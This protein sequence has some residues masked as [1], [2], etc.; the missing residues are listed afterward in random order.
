M[1]PLRR[2]SRL[3]Y[4]QFFDSGEVTRMILTHREKLMW[5]ATPFLRLLWM[6]SFFF[7]GVLFLL[8]LLAS[9]KLRENYFVFFYQ[10]VDTLWADALTK[11]RSTA[12][13]A[14]NGLESHDP[15]LRKL[16]ALRLLEVGAGTGA[17]FKHINRPLKYTNVDPNKEFGS[18]FLEELKKYPEIEMERWVQAYGEDMS[19][20]ENQHFDVVLFSFLLCSVNDPLKVLKEARRVLVKGGRLIFLE[21]VAYPKGTWQRL[22]Q[23]LVQPL[24]KVLNC[25][26]HINREGHEDLMPAAGFSKVNSNCA[27]GDTPVFVNRI[28]YGYAV[29]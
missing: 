4:P 17:N 20:L 5:V 19:E 26:C 10:F 25:N 13:G 15:E 8:P 14:L 9:L 16:G 11:V 24:W 21:H 22:V 1:Y 28:L 18:I 2:P 23:D 12:L 6:Q 27:L 29:S 7:F 3:A